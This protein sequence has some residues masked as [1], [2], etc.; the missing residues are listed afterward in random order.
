MALDGYVSALA[1]DWE[2]G[3]CTTDARLVAALLRRDQRTLE[4]ALASHTAS[5][6]AAVQQPL[7][8]YHAAALADWPE[9]VTALAAAGV[10]PSAADALVH[11]KR[12]SQLAGTLVHASIYQSEQASSHYNAA[13][14]LSSHYSALG[15]AAAMG[16]LQAS[17]T[18][19]GA[20]RLTPRATFWN[21]QAG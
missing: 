10:P 16:H 14:R 11:V 4:A 21:V 19:V 20:G 17:S 3:C 7:L 13:A 5:Q 2:A 18:S 12:G 15:M 8:L 6:L 9:A 1:A